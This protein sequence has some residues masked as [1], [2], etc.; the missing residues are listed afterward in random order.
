LTA[1][2][3]TFNVRYIVTWGPVGRGGFGVTMEARAPEMSTRL[4][5]L[6]LD[7]FTVVFT[8]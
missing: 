5:F 3:T 4:Q 7:V 1:V 2:G 6:S 8:Y